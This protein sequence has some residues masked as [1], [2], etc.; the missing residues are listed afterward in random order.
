MKMPKDETIKKWAK[1]KGKKKFKSEMKERLVILEK[2]Y[3]QKKKKI[4][5]ILK[6]LEKI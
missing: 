5:Y 1:A 6:R 3:K 2:E 4:K